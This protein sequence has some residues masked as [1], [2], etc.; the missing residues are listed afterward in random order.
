MEIA[1]RYGLIFINTGGASSIDMISKNYQ[2]VFGSLLYINELHL[3]E[4]EMIVSEINM[5]LHGL[6]YE[7]SIRLV[8]C[9]S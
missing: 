6:P 8:R 7:K 1:E 4:C 9:K 2:S 5:A 3:S